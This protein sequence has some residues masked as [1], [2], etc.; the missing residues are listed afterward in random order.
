MASNKETNITVF[1]KKWHLNIG[2]VIFGVIFIYLVVT[3]LMY[4]TKE[5]ITAY[6]V[7]EGSILRDNA[8]VGFAVRDEKVVTAEAD[9]YV[10]YFVPE[11]SRAGAKTKVY[12]LS[13]NKL[14]FADENTGEAREL[15]VEERDAL[16]VKTQDFT[17]NFKE[18][19]F[20][21]VYALKDSVQTVLDSKSNQSRQE[22]LNQML[23]AGTQGLT[24]YS[25]ASDGMVI[26][27][28]DG[29]EG[30]TVSD[31]TEA[32]ISKTDYQPV[33][34][35]NNMEVKAGDNIYKLITS[36]IWT[37]VILL[38]DEAAQEM[39]DMTSV[40]VM[41]SKD[42]ETTWADFAIYNTPEA[43]LGFLTF[44]SSMV[45]YAKERYLSIELILE[46]ESGL[47]IPKSSVVSK[48]FYIIPDTY[49]TQG[50]DSTGTGVYVR[51]EDGTVRFTNVDIYNYDTEAGIAYLSPDDFADGTV[52]VRP[53]FEEE[54]NKN[55]K[56]NEKISYELKEKKALEGV[57]NINKGYAVFKQI[58]ILCESE[59][60][61]IVSAGNDYGLANY[62][63]IALNG[64]IVKENDVVF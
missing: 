34:F 17:E 35:H 62:D 18:E 26:Y 45:R 63:R 6:E 5:H 46:D 38:D 54:E 4:L 49:L 19:L 25:A 21:D 1:R 14:D 31:V 23:S 24:V 51:Q 44:E 40:K 28:V 60:Y 27:N 61:Y 11:G 22:Q 32:M 36:D 29:Y 13:P 53:G 33:S 8:Y 9:G 48:D 57:Y 42:H 47:K 10:N 20:S 64:K 3:V 2:I 56:D 41:F 16:L 55:D 43:N 37:L 7:R 50:G 59:E 15:T 58:Q 52:L 30:V 39:A 12:S